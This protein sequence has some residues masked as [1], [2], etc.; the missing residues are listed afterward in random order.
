MGLDLV[1]KLSVARAT[2][3]EVYWANGYTVH[4][5]RG[6]GRDKEVFQT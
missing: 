1:P 6:R 3:V 4:I 2:A 5:S